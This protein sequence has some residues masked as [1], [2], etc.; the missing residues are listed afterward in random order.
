LSGKVTITLP[1][2]VVTSMR[3]RMLEDKRDAIEREIRRYGDHPNGATDATVAHACREYLTVF[4]NVKL[5][6]EKDQRGL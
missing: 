2:T 3:T 1:C 5:P 6:Y 4:D